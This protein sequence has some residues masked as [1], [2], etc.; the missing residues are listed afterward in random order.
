MNG[1]YL[2]GHGGRSRGRLR[3]RRFIGASHLRSQLLGQSR[4]LLATGRHGDFPIGRDNALGIP[5][6]HELFFSWRPGRSRPCDGAD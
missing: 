4:R 5:P 3:P 6:K 2:A 1:T